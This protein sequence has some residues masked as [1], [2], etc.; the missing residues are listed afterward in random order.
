MAFHLNHASKK[1]GHLKQQYDEKLIDLISDVHQHYTTL[2]QLQQNAYDLPEE[3][4]IFEKI[5]EAKYLFL[6][7][8][9]K[10]RQIQADISAPKK[11]KQFRWRKRT[12]RAEDIFHSE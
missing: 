8:E 11:A 5:A 6:L 3:L 7:R 12:N 4:R 10:E 9:A 1:Q 2:S